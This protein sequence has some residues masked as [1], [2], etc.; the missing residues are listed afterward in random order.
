MSYLYFD[1]RKYYLIEFLKNNIDEKILII[2]IIDKY[3]TIYKIIE[4][5]IRYIN[6]CDYVYNK[7]LIKNIDYNYIDD[8]CC[9][10]IVDMISAK[11]S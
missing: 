8:I 5:T 6:L 1:N 3:I 2:Q 9:N 10:A 11:D 7:I 4:I